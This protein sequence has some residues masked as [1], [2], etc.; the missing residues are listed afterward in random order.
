MSWCERR[1][2]SKELIWSPQGGELC[3]F[4]YKI[5]GQITPKIEERIQQYFWK[6]FLSKIPCNYT[7]QTHEFTDLTCLGYFWHFSE[8]TQTFITSNK[9]ELSWDTHVN[10]RA[11]GS[12]AWV[13]V[14][15]LEDCWQPYHF[16]LFFVM[17]TKTLKL[18]WTTFYGKSH[19]LILLKDLEIY[20]G[21]EVLLLKSRVYHI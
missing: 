8:I 1:V 6:G 3:C 12:G 10:F 17:Y 7:H 5:W 20:K 2:T 21:Q 9:L 4:A 16:S 15:R 13:G 14:I 18:Q 11:G 19:I